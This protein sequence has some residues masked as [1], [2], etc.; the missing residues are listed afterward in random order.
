[1]RIEVAIGEAAAVFLVFVRVGAIL[2]F[3]PG[4]SAAY[5][6][7]RIRLLLALALAAV[8][9]P[10]V[11]E[12]LPAIPATAGG[13]F[14]L[15]LKEALVGVFLGL[16]PRIALAAMQTAGTFVAYFASLANAIVQDPVADQQSATVAGFFGMLA[17]VLIFVTDLHHLMLSGIVASYRAFPPGGLLPAGDAAAAVARAVAASFAIGLQL[18]LPALIGC[19]LSNVALGLLGRLMPQLN[20]FFFG[21]P[22]QLSLQLIV[23][24]LTFSG[25]A[26]LFINSFTEALSVFGG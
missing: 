8:T 25:V 26:L 18:A 22:I 7:A 19:I 2:A 4:F 23:M 10:V 5:V 12:A 9:A 14:A 1:M 21:M 15:I 24:I 20:V 3:L 16:I 17:L 13:W 11:A 6:S